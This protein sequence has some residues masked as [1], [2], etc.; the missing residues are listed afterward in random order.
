MP[1]RRMTANDLTCQI[2]HGP[3]NVRNRRIL[4]VAVGAG[5][6]PFTEPITAVRR[7]QRDRR[8]TTALID[9]LLG[10]RLRASWMK[11]R[12]DEGCQGFRE[13][14]KVFGVTPVAP[15]CHH[16]GTCERCCRPS[17]V[18]ESDHAAGSAR[19]GRFAAG[20]G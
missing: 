7:R 10:S 5:E 1:H 13:V 15:G 18:T 14:L 8:A 11:A 9:L 12:G 3:V 4:P 2:R 6:R 19:G 17:S 20:T 16:G